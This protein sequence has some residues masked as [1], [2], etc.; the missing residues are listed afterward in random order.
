MEQ[1]SKKSPSSKHRTKYRE[2]EKRTSQILRA[3]Y[4]PSPLAS[5][6]KLP[7]YKTK[8]ERSESQQSV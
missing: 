3:P 4:G 1:I 5:M 8:P 6:P 2:K 7:K